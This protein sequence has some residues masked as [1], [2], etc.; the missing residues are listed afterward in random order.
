MKIASRS[1]T[2]FA[3]FF[4]ALSSAFAQTSGTVTDHAFAI[5]KGPGQ[6]GFTSLLCASTQIA[7][8]Q[9]AANPTCFALSGDVTMNASGVTAIGAGKVLSSMLGANVYST[10]HTWSGQQTFVAPILGTPASGIL[11]NAT[12][13]PISTGVSGLGTGVATFLATPSSANLRAA[14]TDEAGTG[15][16]YFV[17][18]ALGTP[19]SATLT[20]ATGLPLSTGVTGNLSVSNLNGG[21]AAS[22]ATFWRGDGTWASPSGG[23]GSTLVAPQVRI[24]LTSATPVMGSSVAASTT[25]Y[26]TP[27]GGNLVPIYDGTNLTPT[28]FAEVS[29]ATTDTT[30]SPAAVAASKVYD[31]FCWVD[32]GTNR[33]TRGPAWTNSTT[34][35]YTLT[36][37]NG[38]ALNTS[39]ITNGPAA[40]RGTWVGIIASNATSTIDYVFGSA[41][42]GGGAANFGVWNAYNRVPVATTVTDNGAGYNYTSSTVRQ[43]RASA[44]NQVTFVSG[45]GDAFHVSTNSQFFTAAVANAFSAGGIGINTTS[46][47]S[48][49]RSLCSTG[50]A[51]S[52]LCN[53]TPAAFANA[54]LGL[55]TISRNEQGDGTNSSSVN[56]SSA[57]FLSVVVWN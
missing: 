36:W 57:D 24:T 35:G 27:Q 52:A 26:V 31:V 21:T 5:G 17:G 47:F 11:T 45:G 4:I 18:G 6:T 25:V 43:A 15:A 34:R 12:G 33:C 2:A 20:N 44:G 14:L 1:L 19:A 49:G 50:S 53:E 32:S 51:A 16:A 29:Q 38:I 8:G 7:I 55:T 41:A 10:A 28:P 40:S 48:F 37:V 22:S 9:P 13:L 30:K 42:S 54:A 39:A 3:V 46:A 56:G 23:G